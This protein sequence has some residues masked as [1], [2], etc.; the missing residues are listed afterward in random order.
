MRS[1]HSPSTKV[2]LHTDATPLRGTVYVIKQATCRNCGK[3]I[4]MEYDAGS[5]F[6]ATWSHPDTSREECE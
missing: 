5:E 2:K 1:N 4:Q 6:T 3:P